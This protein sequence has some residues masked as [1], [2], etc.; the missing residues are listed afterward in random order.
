MSQF[1]RDKY[2]LLGQIQ[3]DG[4]VEGGDSAC[5]NGHYVYLTGDNSID[6]VKTFEVSFGGYVR[7][8]DPACTN[9]GFGAYYSSPWGGVISRDQMAGIIAALFKVGDKGAIL[10]HLAHRA[11]SL[12]LFSYNTIKNGRKPSEA[13]RKLSDLTLFDVWAT[14]L[15][16]VGTL[17]GPLKHVLYPVLCVLDL[18]Q[19]LATVLFANTHPMNK[20]PINYTLRLLISQDYQPTFISRLSWKLCDRVRLLA[21]HFNYWCGWRKNCGM[22]DLYKERLK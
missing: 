5:W 7:H 21:R 11:C 15:R 14:E 4:S 20:D 9:N 8:P 1:T 18:H 22:Y 2:G 16:L 6:Y 10:R 17:L 19:L 13:R 12:F 3:G